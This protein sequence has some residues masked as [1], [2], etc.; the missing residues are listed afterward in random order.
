[1]EVES[2]LRKC[3]VEELREIATEIRVAD[4]ADKTKIQVLRLIGDA[5]DS[6]PDDDQKMTLMKRMI[7]VV[8]T[9]IMLSLCHVLGGGKKETPSDEYVT[10]L[11]GALAGN[12]A[13][14]RDL[15]FS[16]TIDSGSESDDV[17]PGYEVLRSEQMSGIIGRDLGN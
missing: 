15:K 3:T 2:I 11:V 13:L 14:R 5:I 9:K 6:L 1:M 7:P 16:G 8:P 17:S 4:V 10:K 12:N